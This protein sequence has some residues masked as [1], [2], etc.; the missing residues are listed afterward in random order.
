MPTVVEATLGEVTVS[1][2]T[3][4][5]AKQ[6][7]GAVLIRSVIRWSW[8]RPPQARNPVRALISFP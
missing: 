6:A 5:V 4:R 3:G 1:I 2:E 7:R 8:S